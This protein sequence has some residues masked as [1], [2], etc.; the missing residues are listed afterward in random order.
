MK[1]NVTNAL[2]RKIVTAHICPPIPY[3][4]S[5]WIAYYDG[6]AELGEYGYG[7]TEAR[8]I[9]DLKMSYPTD[10]TD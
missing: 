4:E 1:D 7:S 6:D 8:A 9:T 10:E 5:D 3:R 2:V